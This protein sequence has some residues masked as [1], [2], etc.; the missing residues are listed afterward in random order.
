[1]DGVDKTDKHRGLHRDRPEDTRVW[2]DILS[3]GG[4]VPPSNRQEEMQSASSESTRRSFSTQPGTGAASCPQ[5]GSFCSPSVLCSGLNREGQDWRSARA[6]ALRGLPSSLMPPPGRPLPEPRVDSGQHQPL[7]LGATGDAPPVSP[8]GAARVTLPASQPRE[9]SL[10]SS[11]PAN[12]GPELEDTV[13][14][15]VLNSASALFSLRLQK[16]RDHAWTCSC[17]VF[18][19]A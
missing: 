10:L 6:A 3:A 13:C 18:F 14:R 9:S 11:N 16:S 4:Q 7:L 5:Q 19:Q 15:K 12:G 17:A 1:M 8:A 2:G